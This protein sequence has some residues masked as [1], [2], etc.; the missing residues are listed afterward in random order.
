VTAKFAYDVTHDP[1][2]PIVPVRVGMTAGQ[3]EAVVPFLVDTGADVTV[4]PA[5]LA[6]ELD[7][8]PVGEMMIEGAT[9][10]TARVPIFRAELEIGGIA[11]SVQVA[12]LGQ[13]TLIG[14][15][16]LNQWTLVL[17][18]RAGELE[19]ETG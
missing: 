1:P 9:G 13:E 18:G 19:I 10:R 11:V 8:P 14:R 3:W 16:V 2:A 6:R 17:R 12:A 5:R 15:D 4:I 7:L